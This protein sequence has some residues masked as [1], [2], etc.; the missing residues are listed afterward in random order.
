MNNKKRILILTAD[1]GFGHRSAAIAVEEALKERYEDAV[2]IIVLNPLDDKR[3][4][5]LLRDSQS[6]YDKMVRNAPELYKLGYDA[7]DFTVTSALVES[8]L[9]VMLFDVLRDVLRRLDPDVIVSTY[10]LY[11]A[12]LTSI[13]TLR[14]KP[15]V[16]LL[17]VIT[18]LATVHRIWFHANVDQLLVPTEVVRQ[19]AI[20][21]GVAPE[22]IHITGIPVHPNIAN[23]KRTKRQIRTDLGW[24]PDQ[25]TI[26]AVGSK[27]VQGLIEYLNVINHFGQEIQLAV[28]CGKDDEMYRELQEMHWHI[29]MH[30]YEYVDNMPDMMHAADLLVCKAGGL[31]VTEA[32]ACGLP[33]LLIDI[34]PGQEMGNMDYVVDNG[35][36]EHIE[37]PIQMLEALHHLTLKGG[38]LLKERSEAA[39][40]LGRPQAAFEIADMAFQAEHQE[41]NKHSGNKR[42]TIIDLLTVNQVNLAEDDLNLK[43]D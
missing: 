6:D 27:R 21:A 18:D 13:F 30:L 4:P 35:A 23:E 10:P 12:P 37:T 8:A 24:T 42:K 14:R 11:Q 34:L 3:A 5:A 33:M 9:T 15:A 20:D 17:E 38:T 19:L 1:A 26:L 2:E 39:C 36:G 43:E 41:K 16:P 7:S 40:R 22:K 29:P 28:V 31:T 32:L 25:R